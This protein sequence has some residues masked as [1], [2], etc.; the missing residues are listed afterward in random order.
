MYRHVHKSAAISCAA[1]ACL[2]LAALSGCS[3]S[4]DSSNATAVESSAVS[5]RASG[6]AFTYTA[7]ASG[8]SKHYIVT[9]GG[10]DRLQSG[11]PM[12]DFEGPTGDGAMTEAAEVAPEEMPEAGETGST[13]GPNT[14]TES[15][16][17]AP[18]GV[19]LAWDGLKNL[20]QSKVEADWLSN[21][22]ILEDSQDTTN[23]GLSY[24]MMES[25]ILVVA[26]KEGVVI[27]W[28]PA[29]VSGQVTISRNGTKVADV[30]AAAG[31]FVDGGVKSLTEYDYRINRA[32]TGDG[33][34][35]SMALD[36][37]IPPDFERKTL[38]DMAHLQAAGFQ[39]LLPASAK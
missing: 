26:A 34:W 6:A 18:T 19:P 15:R 12:K 39:G 21:W 29:K 3:N 4:A 16:G 5:G 30:D 9:P 8:S 2:S 7:V 25:G 23:L 10:G 27:S 20:D 37:A 28:D 35:A 31:H 33:N 1:I 22:R 36:V 14:A 38:Q 13:E 11:D 24:G 32:Q 17:P